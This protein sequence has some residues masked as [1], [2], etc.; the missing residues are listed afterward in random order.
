MPSDSGTDASNS[1][2]NTDSSN[3]AS[4][5][6]GSHESIASSNTDSASSK[7]P[8]QSSQPTQS[9]QANNDN[10]ALDG[11]SQSRKLS[12]GAIGGIVVGMLLVVAAGVLAFIW[13]RNKRSRRLYNST[14]FEEFKGFSPD[15]HTNL[16]A[17]TTAVGYGG[18]RA[19]S[20]RESR[21]YASS[22]MSGFHGPT[23][24]PQARMANGSD[25][26]RSDIS[27]RQLDEH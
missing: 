21:G 13:N 19:E 22:E 5:S 25:R 15:S 8:P 1:G 14:D 4:D 12:G 6:T 2:S 17:A 7:P 27:F 3:T 18:G 24:P 26:P 9:K 23:S 11:E 16:M 10:S 20:V